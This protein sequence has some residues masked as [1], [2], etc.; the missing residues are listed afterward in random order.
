MVLAHMTFF[1]H[2]LTLLIS[3]LLLTGCA[4][5]SPTECK[6]ADWYNKGAS[7]GA[8]GVLPEYLAKHRQACARV[9]V[10][11][12]THAW[13]AGR[14]EGLKNYCTEVNAYNVGLKGKSLS[15]VCGF[16]GRVTLKNMQQ[17]YEEGRHIHRL[18]EKI[19]D[20]RRDIERY[21]DDYHDKRHDFRKLDKPT[22]SQRREYHREMRYIDSRIRSLESDI[23]RQERLLSDFIHELN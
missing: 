16:V 2:S 22:R 4:T 12:N 14:E 3:T 23:D 9:K 17:R 19:K 21:R 20:L 8:R 13:L 15:P 11:P 6:Q 5:M 18:E 1:K 7:D 10:V